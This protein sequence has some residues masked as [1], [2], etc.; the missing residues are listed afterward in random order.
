MR[1]RAARP[2][3]VPRLKEI[4]DL[5]G[6]SFRTVGMPEIADDD[7]PSLLTLAGYQATGRA[8]VAVDERDRSVGYALVDDV[9]GNVHIEQ[10]SV[11]PAYAHR[12][13]G[14]ALLDDIAAQ[15]SAHGVRAMTL[16]TFADVPWNAPYY[17]RCGFRVMATDEISAGLAAIR[18][19]EAAVGLDR[20]PRVCMVRP[21]P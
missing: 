17:E 8:I 20:W 6:E 1:H 3:D 15:A 18:S 16:T 21:L 7:E 5:A 19:A 4:E 11:D 9:D 13:I 12:G 14:R 10:I 2:D